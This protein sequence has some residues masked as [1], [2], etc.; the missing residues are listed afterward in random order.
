MYKISPVDLEQ[1]N[2]TTI[3]NF[4]RWSK[5]YCKVQAYSLAVQAGLFV[6]LCWILLVLLLVMVHH[7]SKCFRFWCPGGNNG[8]LSLLKASLVWF[9]TLEPVCHILLGIV[10]PLIVGVTTYGPRKVLSWASQAT[11]ST[12]YCASVVTVS[13]EVVADAKLNTIT[14]SRQLYQ[15]RIFWHYMQEKWSLVYWILYIC[16]HAVMQWVTKDKTRSCKST[17][18]HF[19]F[20]FF[21]FRLV[22]TG[23]GAHLL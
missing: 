6:T 4:P 5:C 10:G 13:M 9:S 17:S 7:C 22:V 18:P 19:D 16:S 14:D 8:R 1:E 23:I 3:A 20:S 15:A 2:F 11:A 21:H 12:L